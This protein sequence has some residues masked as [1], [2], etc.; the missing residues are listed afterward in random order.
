MNG[1]LPSGL[2]CCS[3]DGHAPDANQFEFSFFEHSHFVR[4]LKALQNCLKHR[5]DSFASRRWKR[6]ASCQFKLDALSQ[7]SSVTAASQGLSTPHSP[8]QPSNAK[9]VRRPGNLAKSRLMHAP[10]HFIRRRKTLD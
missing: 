2:V 4:L 1:P 9:G 6:R 5:L 10:E 3:A 8:V 7:N